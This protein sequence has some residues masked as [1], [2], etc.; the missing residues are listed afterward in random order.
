[1]NRNFYTKLTTEQVVTVYGLFN[2]LKRLRVIG[3]LEAHTVQQM[4]PIE[5]LGQYDV[6][7]MTGADYAIIKDGYS[8]D[9]SRIQGDELLEGIFGRLK[10]HYSSSY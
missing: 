5:I 6:I 8:S 3:H 10:N 7:D 4:P 1:M 2:F 9:K